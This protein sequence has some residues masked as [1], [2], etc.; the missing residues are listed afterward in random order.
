MFGKMKTGEKFPLNGRQNALIIGVFAFLF[1]SCAKENVESLKAEKTLGCNNDKEISYA[2]D[3]VPIL[4]ANCGTQ[5][6]CHSNGAASG[7]VKL[8]DFD[9]VKEVAQTGLLKKSLFHE[10]GVSP[11][12]KNLN[13]L[14]DCT[15][16]IIQKWLDAGFPN[17]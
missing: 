14:D 6:G 7:G 8:E 11:M 17:N 15:L 10:S 13:K 4:Q 9:G 12:P 1:S 3:I 5:S 16:S 2:K